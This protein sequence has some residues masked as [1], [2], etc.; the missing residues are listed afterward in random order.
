MEVE[1]R[2]LSQLV[3]KLDRMSGTLDDELI[4]TTTSVVAYVH[5]TVPPYPPPP[6]GSGYVRTGT[7]GR[8]IS[9][10][11]RVLGSE[12]VGVIGSPTVYSPYVISDVEV[13]GRGPQAW[14]HVGR[15]WTLQGVVE[16]AK[17]G[18]IHL[19]ERMIQR[20]ISGG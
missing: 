1:I 9:T 7:L 12:I 10:D 8:E 16:K 13:D 18:I 19:Y 17:D 6:A 2:G 4:R 11:V 3:S 14:M 15:W 5:S 20:L